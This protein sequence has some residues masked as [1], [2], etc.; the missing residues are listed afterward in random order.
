MQV[1]EC[2]FLLLQILFLS[3]LLR[4][5]FSTWT[6]EFSTGVQEFCLFF[7]SILFYGSFSLHVSVLPYH[8]VDDINK[9]RRGF[10]RSDP[11]HSHNLR[12]Y[13]FCNFECC[14]QHKK[15]QQRNLQNCGFLSCEKNYKFHSISFICCL[16]YFFQLTEQQKQNKGNTQYTSAKFHLL[17][18]FHWNERF[19]NYMRLGFSFAI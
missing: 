3:I 9:E 7:T 18:Y 12:S 8:Y 13:L 14:V 6:N 2:C 11:M 17:S 15:Q 5:F 19:D 16:C 4:F 10:V 1:A